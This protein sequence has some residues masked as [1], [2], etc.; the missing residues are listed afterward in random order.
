MEKLLTKQYLSKKKQK[1]KKNSIYKWRVCGVV[2]GVGATSGNIQWN[3][4]LAS[5]FFWYFPYKVS[6]F[7]N[8]WIYGGRPRVK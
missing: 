4:R 5:V 8:R 7:N 3:L 1:N 2:G 6:Q